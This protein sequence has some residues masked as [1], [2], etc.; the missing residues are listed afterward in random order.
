MIW[1]ACRKHVGELLVRP[2]YKCVFGDP[3]TADY[4]DFKEF[5]KAWLKRPT[6]DDPLILDG[7]AQGQPLKMTSDWE[8]D[9]AKEVAQ[10]LSKLRH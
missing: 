3:K 9:R 6:E 5:Q 10:E 1:G 7:Q 8:V 4:T 2:V